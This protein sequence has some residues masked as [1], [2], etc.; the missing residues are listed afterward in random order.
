MGHREGGLTLGDLRLF[1]LAMSMRTQGCMR[2]SPNCI[3]LRR[4]GFCGTFDGKSN[5]KKYRAA[6]M[7][8]R[9][10][11]KSEGYELSLHKRETRCW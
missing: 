6:E 9:P 4:L 8:E 5:S 3:Q 10:Q 11:R 2:Q 7:S 1:S